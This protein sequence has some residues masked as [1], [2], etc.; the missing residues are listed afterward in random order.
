MQTVASS[1]E[2]CAV[3]CLW[4]RLK[5]CALLPVAH[6]KKY[7]SVHCRRYYSFLLPGRRILVK[8]GKVAFRKCV[9]VSGPRGKDSFSGDGF[10]CVLAVIFA[11]PAF[12]FT[13]EHSQR[14]WEGRQKRTTAKAHVQ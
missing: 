7:V 14:D 1:A 13:F 9:R 6:Q 3:R 4:H 2:L 10:V 5:R 11:W 8:Y 12:R